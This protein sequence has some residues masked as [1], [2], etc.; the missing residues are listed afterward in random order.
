MLYF[1]ISVLM[2]TALFPTLQ[3]YIVNADQLHWQIDSSIV[4]LMVDDFFGLSEK[5]TDFS[6]EGDDV[7]SSVDYLSIRTQWAPFNSY[8]IQTCKLPSFNFI[9]DD[10]ALEKFTPP[11]QA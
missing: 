3:R 1:S 10:P 11:P 2:N 5:E 9:Q 8:L 6:D 4:E 7:D